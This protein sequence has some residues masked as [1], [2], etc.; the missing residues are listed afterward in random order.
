[1]PS[2]QAP[3]WFSSTQAHDGMKSNRALMMPDGLLKSVT[4]P[5]REAVLDEIWEWGME[6]TPREACG[7]IV[8]NGTRYEVHH[9]LNKADDPHRG[10]RL[11]AEIIGMVVADRAIWNQSTVIWH[12]HPGGTIGASELDVKHAVIGLKYIVM[13]MPGGEV[14]SF[15]TEGPESID[16]GWER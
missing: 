5:S 13:S 3:E 11:D 9:L 7:L 10:Y 2:N 16:T 12:T 4:L 14:R 1:M 6:Q 8:E 15:N